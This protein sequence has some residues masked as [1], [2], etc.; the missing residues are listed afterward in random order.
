[1]YI[2]MCIY[3]Y[4][5]IYDIGVEPFYYS[6]PNGETYPYTDKLMYVN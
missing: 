2:N 4:L 3:V 5:Y 1:M 6:G